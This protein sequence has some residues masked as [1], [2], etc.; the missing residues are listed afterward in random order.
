MVS[1]KCMVLARMLDGS[2]RILVNAARKLAGFTRILV[3]VARIY[4]LTRNLLWHEN[5]LTRILL[6][7]LESIFLVGP[8]VVARIFLRGSYCRRSLFVLVQN[9]FLQ[10]FFSLI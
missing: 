4:F 10:A 2:A 9:L 5:F 8:S 3:D 1:Q 7:S 6:L